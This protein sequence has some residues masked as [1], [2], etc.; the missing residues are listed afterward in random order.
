M[1]T[2][3]KVSTF[4]FSFGIYFNY[5]KDKKGVLQ[6]HYIIIAPLNN[7]IEYKIM[8]ILCKN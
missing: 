1:W 2:N 3:L 6:N 7:E 8:M 5:V 4:F